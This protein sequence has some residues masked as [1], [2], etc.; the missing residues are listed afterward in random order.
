MLELFLALKD[1][2]QFGLALFLCALAWWIGAGPERLAASA[3]AAMFLLDIPNHLL[4]GDATWVSVDWGHAVIDVLTAGLLVYCGLYAN[5]MYPL[6]LAAFQLISATSHLSRELS[7]GMAGQA[8]SIMIITPSYFELL[9]LALGI[10]S[11][12]QRKRAWGSYRSWRS[13]SP[14][15]QVAVR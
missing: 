4:F 6:W 2:V 12:M 5:R 3:I 15:L 7:H 8:Y 11:H 9:I 14:H 10:H 1:E 13:C